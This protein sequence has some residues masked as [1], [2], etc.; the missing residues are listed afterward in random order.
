MKALCSIII[1][2]KNEE[3][4]IS[5][6]LSAV[7]D[8]TYTN[9]E[10]IIVDNNSTDKTLDN[11]KSFP[12]NKILNISEYLP[13]KS[14]NIGIKQATGKYIVCLS[15]H[16][17]PVNN[18]WLESL[19]N[20]IEESDNY[21]GVYGRQEPMSFS[22]DADKRDLLLTFGLDKRIQIK[23]SFFHNANSIIQ[24]KFLDEAPFDDSI[25]N[26]EDRIWAQEMILK[27]RNIVYEP[28]ASVYHYHGIHQDGDNERCTNIV[29]IIESFS[30]SIIPGG[31][32]DPKKIRINALIPSKGKPV[33]FGDVPQIKYTIDSALESKYIDKV[34]VIAD[35]IET[36]K[37]A[38]S[39]GAECPFKRPKNLS[40]KYVTLESVFKYSIEQLEG[41]G[42][43]SDLI[44]T[45]EP[46][47]PFR[48]D[49]LVDNIIELTLIEG[50]DSVIAAVRESGSIWRENAENCERLDSGDS[51]RLY[52]EKTLIGLR[53][54]CCVTH[55]VFL[56][57]E[58]I[59]G[60]KVGLYEVENQLC[61]IEIRDNKTLLNTDLIKELNKNVKVNYD[62]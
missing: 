52:K 1:R 18:Q 30:K 25:T 17:I 24:K 3:R 56:R 23:D 9:I 54:V 42:I 13:G 37:L 7:Y 49:N 14:L 59:L 12:V 36:I 53:G 33:Y 21:A 26:I 4:W 28:K 10:V 34:F 20:T 47:F 15:G 44:V 5:S 50:H 16:C 46:S 38:Q 61:S 6:C 60:N 31:S 43:L 48:T 58:K 51:P 29:K 8:Q 27:G 32:F 19:V 2:T 39:L 62:N 11:I 45:L 41:H 55:P 40:K 22:S 35:D 57:D